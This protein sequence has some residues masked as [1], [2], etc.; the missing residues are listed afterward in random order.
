MFRVKRTHF[1][2]EKLRVIFVQTNVG[3]PKFS[4]G[5]FCGVS[6]FSQWW[7]GGWSEQGIG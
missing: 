6:V 4:L 5:P 7:G 3:V 2:I 1:I